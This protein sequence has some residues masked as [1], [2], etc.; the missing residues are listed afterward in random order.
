MRKRRAIVGI[1]AAI[2]LI[3]FVIVAAALAFVALNMGLFT[4]QKSKETIQRGLGEASSALEVDGSVTGYYDATAQGVTAISVPVKV[5]PGREAV[6][7]STSETTL[8]FM[9]GTESYENIY[10]AVYILGYDSTNNY[11]VL[12]DA[13]DTTQQ[14]IMD[15]D[16]TTGT[17]S[18]LT[19]LPSLKLLAANLAALS[20]NTFDATNPNQIDASGAYLTSATTPRAFTVFLRTTNDDSVLSFGEKA[21]IIIIT[22]QA[23]GAS[24]YDTVVVEVKPPEGAPLTVERMIPASLPSGGG[25]IDLG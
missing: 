19:N 3:A 6:D 7:L 13:T 18:P 12:I 21:L 15:N 17:T 11:Y 20:E 2:V 24:A 14:Y 22:P 4:T 25:A 5:A 16:P 23:G 9:L 10:H 1:E 8:K